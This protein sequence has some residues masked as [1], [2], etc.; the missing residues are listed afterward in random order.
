MIIIIVVGSDIK[1]QSREI[2]SLFKQTINRA[3]NSCNGLI[4]F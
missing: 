1:A 2:K 4:K 3:S